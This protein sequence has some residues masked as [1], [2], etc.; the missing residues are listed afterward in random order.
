MYMK[1]RTLV[2]YSAIESTLEQLH[3]MH[4]TVSEM[5]ETASMGLWQGSMEH[6]IQEKVISCLIC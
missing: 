4:S 2:P 6:D 3:Y 5:T 1:G